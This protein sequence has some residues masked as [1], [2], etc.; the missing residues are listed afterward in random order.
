M[1]LD[2]IDR[3]IKENWLCSLAT[4]SGEIPHCSLMGYV[5]D[6]SLRNLYL[7]TRPGSIKYKNIRNNPNVSILIDNRVVL[8]ED[9]FGV[10][11]LTVFGK[12]R[13]VEDDIFAAEIKDR[14]LTQRPFLESL[15]SDGNAQIIEVELKNV[16]MARGP[17][18]AVYSDFSA[19]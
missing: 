5:S 10:R 14:I 2:T 11:A 4:T 9:P 16:I 3:I 12:A 15:A 1:D 8:K 6:T 13:V 19:S 17:S 7:I 18:D